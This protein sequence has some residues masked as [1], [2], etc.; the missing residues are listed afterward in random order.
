MQ[1]AQP[2]EADDVH[3]VVDHLLELVGGGDVEAGGE[4]VAGVEAQPEP[5]APTCQRHE[6]GE[7]LE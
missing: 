1:A 2:I 4:Q 3:A 6:L 7:L 5:F